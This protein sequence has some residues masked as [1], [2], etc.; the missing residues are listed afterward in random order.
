MLSSQKINFFVFYLNKVPF[1]FL[2]NFFNLDIK[3]VEKNEELVL[4]FEYCSDYIWLSN[5]YFLFKDKE[6][7]NN[8]IQYRK[9]GGFLNLVFVLYF[10]ILITF[11]S[12]IAFFVIIHCY[13]V[14]LKEDDFYSTLKN[15]IKKE[16]RKTGVIKF[17]FVNEPSDYVLDYRN[18]PRKNVEFSDLINKFRLEVEGNNSSLKQKAEDWF[19]VSS[20][21]SLL[22]NVFRAIYTLGFLHLVKNY[23]TFPPPV[24]VPYVFKILETIITKSFRI[25]SK[26]I[27]EVSKSIKIFPRNVKN[28]YRA[29]SAYRKSDSY[30]LM[31]RPVNLFK[32]KFF[33][34]YQTSLNLGSYHKNIMYGYV[35]EIS[36][37]TWITYEQE[38]Y[39]ALA[40][41]I[42]YNIHY[43]LYNFP[44]FKEDLLSYD[45]KCKMMIDNKGILEI[46]PEGDIFFL[47]AKKSKDWIDFKIYKFKFETVR[48]R[49]YNNCTIQ[50]YDWMVKIN[51]EPDP[52]LDSSSLK[53]IR[54]NTSSMNLNKAIKYNRNDYLKD[55]RNIG[56]YP[57]KLKTDKW[58]DF[59]LQE[60]K[61]FLHDA[62]NDACRFHD[63]GIIYDLTGTQP[64]CIRKLCKD[65]YGFEYNL[66]DRGFKSLD[67][68]PYSFMSVNLNSLQEISERGIQIIY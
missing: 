39:S 58:P 65:T 17:Y 64:V 46:L 3:K 24:F 42:S 18:F 2:I 56:N 26:I 9:D 13:C 28:V 53:T 63:T 25:T 40:K 54:V 49:V 68:Q 31:Y 55:P 14:V 29:F 34:N 41:N 67:Y 27:P 10:S 59:A 4:I 48:V 5:S 44:L 32:R 50:T 1:D 7:L 8:H 20:D 66:Y 38:L 61:N 47:Y 36:D 35:P 23:L 57:D 45:I 15:Q 12:I 33:R 22:S 16:F 19:L 21:K 6:K 52:F 11:L 43:D 60:I 37:F 30:K 62:E 51:F